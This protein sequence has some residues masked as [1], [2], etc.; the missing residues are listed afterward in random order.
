MDGLKLNVHRVNLQDKMHC[1]S[2]VACAILLQ[3]VLCAVLSSGA[4]PIV[5]D[6]SGNPPIAALNRFIKLQDSSWQAPESLG[7]PKIEHS[8]LSKRAPAD[9]APVHKPLFLGH[10]PIT[11]D[12]EEFEPLDLNKID[13]HLRTSQAN[14]QAAAAGPKNNDPVSLRERARDL[15]Q[16]RNALITTHRTA[17]NRFVDTQV[18]IGYNY[19]DATGRSDDLIAGKAEGQHQTDYNLVTKKIKQLSSEKDRHMEKLADE[20]NALLAEAKRDGKL[21][22]VTGLNKVDMS[23][24]ANTFAR[25][26]RL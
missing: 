7:V 22:E 21:G 19:E 8:R 4:T 24:T 2:T 20:R 26:S 1:R 23:N 9:G 16:R 10:Q 14:L 11:T 12:H 15:V 6:A 3:L 13:D 17:E 25:L 18:Q 5:K